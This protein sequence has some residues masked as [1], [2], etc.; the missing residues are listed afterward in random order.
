MRAYRSAASRREQREIDN[1][2]PALVMP[3]DAEAL[4]GGGSGSSVGSSQ[5]LRTSLSLQ[6]LY[7]FY[8]G[9]LSAASWRLVSEEQ[10]EA[11]IYSTWEVTDEEGS[12][13]DGTL[14]V[15]F[16][17]PDSSDATMSPEFADAYTVN[18]SLTL[19]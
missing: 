17:Y 11:T 4:G 10:S 3:D 5:Y 6:E 9:Q 15:T 1:L 18:V 2:M 16:G 12:L 13:I 19:R 8:S 7:D 14:E